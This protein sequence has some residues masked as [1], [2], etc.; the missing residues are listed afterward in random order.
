MSKIMCLVPSNAP[1]ILAAPRLLNLF[2]AR[3]DKG[4]GMMMLSPSLVLLNFREVK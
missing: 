4:I 3:E 2:F 1:R